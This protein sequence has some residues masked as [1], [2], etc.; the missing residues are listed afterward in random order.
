MRNLLVLKAALLFV[1]AGFFAVCGS[2]AAQGA[3]NNQ[4][5]GGGAKTKFSAAEIS[6]ILAEFE[7]TTTMEPYQ[8]GATSTIYAETPT[9]ARFIITLIECDDF[10]AATGCMAASFYTGSTNAVLAYED[11]NTFNMESDV[12]RAVNVAEQRLIIYET[13]LIFIGGVSPEHIKAIAYFFFMDMERHFSKQAGASV[14]VSASGLRSEPGKI[15]NLTVG[16]PKTRVMTARPAAYK[17]E[18]ALSAA[19]ANNWNVRFLTDDQK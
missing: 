17:I 16:D 7:I 2:A 15:D 11:L 3:S 12:T 5:M 9:G 19:V 13:R 10:A 14:Q 18:H 1:A 8:G 6:A 4:L